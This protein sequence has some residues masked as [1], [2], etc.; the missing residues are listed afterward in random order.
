[1]G[2]KFERE[3]YLPSN[4]KINYTDLCIVLG[5]SLDNAIEACKRITDSSMPKEIKLYM[6]YRDKYMI[7]VVTNTCDKPPVKMGRFYKSSK[8]LPELHGIGLQSIDRTVKKYN[9]NM[10]IKYENNIFELEIVMSTA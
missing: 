10:V 1:M 8:P 9:G 6:N 7:I 5:N 3:L 2:I 4:I